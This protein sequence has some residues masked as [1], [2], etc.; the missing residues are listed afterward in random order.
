MH[1]SPR[2]DLRRYRDFETFTAELQ[3]KI[4]LVNAES[5]DIITSV[6]VFKTEVEARSL[7][8]GKQK[9]ILQPGPPLTPDNAIAT[10]VAYNVT[11]GIKVDGPFSARSTRF[12]MAWAEALALTSSNLEVLHHQK[13]ELIASAC[14]PL[15]TRHSSQS[16]TKHHRLGGPSTRFTCNLQ[17]C[18]PHRLREVCNN[19]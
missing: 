9:R 3:G 1:P 18:N 4:P 12:D 19:F 7:R 2:L 10:L 14:I 5:A 6:L 16:T 11:V 17:Y 8:A 15:Q 13:R